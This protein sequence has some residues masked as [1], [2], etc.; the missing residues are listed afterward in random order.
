MVT[1]KEKEREIIY[2]TS[3]NDVRE[4][5]KELERERDGMDG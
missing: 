2:L 4:R 3:D 5:A 1:K